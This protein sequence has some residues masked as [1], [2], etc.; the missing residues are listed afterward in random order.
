MSSAPLRSCLLGDHSPAR[1]KAAFQR[2]G[3]GFTLHQVTDQGDAPFLRAVGSGRRRTPRV[4]S[5]RIIPYS[6][7]DH[8]VNGRPIAPSP[9]TRWRR[10]S[11]FQRSRERSRRSFRL[12][13]IVK[14]G[15][16]HVVMYRT[17][18][19]STPLIAH[20]CRTVMNCRHSLRRHR[21]LQKVDT[22]SS[23]DSP[24]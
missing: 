21:D 20:G 10:S 14:Y 3:I 15:Q 12:S 5:V 7:A 22:R 2:L 1:A 18:K 17:S 8:A 6:Y 4:Q 13:S 16:E 9:S 24:S 19:P 11:G 23:D